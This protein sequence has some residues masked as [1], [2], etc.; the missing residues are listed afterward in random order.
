MSRF[1]EEHY[2]SKAYKAAVSRR[3]KTPEVAVEAERRASRAQYFKNSLKA[4][5]AIAR[6]QKAG[7]RRLGGL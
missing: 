4:R 1:R 6:A 3:R 7:Q 5:Q 2:E